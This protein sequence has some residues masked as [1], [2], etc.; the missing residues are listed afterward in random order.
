MFRL[1]P[2]GMRK[3]RINLRLNMNIKDITNITKGFKMLD[4][5]K[6][7]AFLAKQHMSVGL[8]IGTSYIKLAVLQVQGK[9]KVLKKIVKLPIDPE[10]DLSSAI[11]SLIKSEGIN[12]RY[13][14]ISLSGPSVI[15]RYIT[16]P[17]MTPE[18]LKS[19]MQFEAKEYIPFSLEEVNLDCSILKDKIQDNKMLV[20]LVA[21]KKSIIQERLSLLEKAGLIP[22]LIDVDCLCLANAFNN[23]YQAM[24]TKDQPQGAKQ[25]VVGLLNIGS[26][27]TNM[28]IIENGVLKFSRDI[29]FGG[30]DITKRLLD[31]SQDYTQAEMLKTESS[32]SQEVLNR[33]EQA[34]NSL[35]SEVRLSIDYYE[36]QSGL[37]IDKIFL[38]GGSSILANITDVLTHLL[39]I[40]VD[41]YNF[42]AN[43][44]LDPA[45][46]Q[47]KLKDGN[48]YAVSLGLALR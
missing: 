47:D 6:I 34:I 39:G 32:K 21:V 10:K 28:A 3:I 42:F 20:L 9:E 16:F 1:F 46:D 15:M 26:R 24:I 12:E 48:S 11:S 14:N 36:N 5:I 44:T 45:L 37:A 29:S 22:R 7:P 18:E 23:S 31:I 17:S 2:G 8:D 19:T 25:E 27:F 40:Q 38:S 33:I 13:V 4:K 30:S 35:S 43:I 41:S